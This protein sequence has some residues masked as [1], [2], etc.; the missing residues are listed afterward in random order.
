LVDL[1]AAQNEPSLWSLRM[2]QAHTRAKGDDK[3]FIAC[4]E[5]LIQRMNRP[6][7]VAALLARAGEAATRLQNLDE[8]KALLE[9]AATE[10]PGDVVTWGLLADVRQRA[11]DARGAAEAC[12][13]LARTS[14]VGEHQ[15]LAW[16]DAGRIWL[17][18][19]KDEER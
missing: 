16:Y 3:A 18:E 10:D 13:S 1:A 17:D 15:L 11:G 5:S 19:V 8:S 6:Q 14:V 2:L 9:R 12:E 4:N 7:E